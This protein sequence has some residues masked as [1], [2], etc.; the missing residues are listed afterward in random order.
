[1]FYAGL[2]ALALG[3]G[4]GLA[5]GALSVAAAQTESDAQGRAKAI[6]TVVGAPASVNCAAVAA[7]GRYDDEALAYC[8]RAIESERLSRANRIVTRINRGALH[9][10]RGANNPAAKAAEGERALAD[11]DFVIAQDPRNADAHL[12][13]GAALVMVGKHGLAV[14]A[15]TESLG[16]GV[17]QPHKAYLNRGAA[18]ESLGD[19]RGALED[20]STALEIN[21]EWAIAEAELARFARVNRDRLAER[22]REASPARAAD[23]RAQ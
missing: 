17:K 6:T 20:Y 18:R 8:D 22:V 9:L 3:A 7:A 23:V 1:M 12:N 13:R 4:A 2:R 11:F 10:R 14:G 19:L 5:L 16:L 15:I 21:P